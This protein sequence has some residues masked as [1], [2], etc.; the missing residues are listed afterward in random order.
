MLSA[1]RWHLFGGTRHGGTRRVA[2]FGNHR[3]I[4]RSPEIDNG[5]RRGCSQAPSPAGNRPVDQAAFFA[6]THPGERADPEDS[7]EQLQA[8]PDPVEPGGHPHM[9]QCGRVVADD[10]GH[11]TDQDGQPDRDGLPAGQDELGE[12]TQDETDDDR[13]DDAV[14]EDHD[15]LR[16]PPDEPLARQTSWLSGDQGGR[17][18]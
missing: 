10:R 4:R 16:W 7:E 12:H 18:R 17:G 11:D 9:Q 3:S 8:V 15:A 13:A 14:T 5:A 1:P 6:Y 2:P